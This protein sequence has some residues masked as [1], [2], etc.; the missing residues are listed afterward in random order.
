MQKWD[1]EA[2]CGKE[3][4]DVSNVER[5]QDMLVDSEKYNLSESFKQ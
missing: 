3:K 1:T 4:L 5:E 2:T